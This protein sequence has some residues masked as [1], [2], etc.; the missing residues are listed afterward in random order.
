MGEKQ[1]RKAEKYEKIACNCSAS[2][3]ACGRVFALKANKFIRLRSPR[4]API[5]FRRYPQ[6]NC[7]A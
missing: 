3:S 7:S 2:A 5:S 4:C 1:H 6:L